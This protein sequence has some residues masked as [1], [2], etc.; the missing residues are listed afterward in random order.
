MRFY[1]KLYFI[2]QE[3][4]RVILIL[5]PLPIVQLTW[6]PVYPVGYPHFLVLVT[7]ARQYRLNSQP[8][9]KFELFIDSTYILKVGDNGFLRDDKRGHETGLE[10]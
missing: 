9:M 5:E 8:F 1:T 10:I 4:Y 3:S 7:L 2:L 6:T